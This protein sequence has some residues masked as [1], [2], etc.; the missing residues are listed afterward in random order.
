M[1]LRTKTLLA[2]GIT[3]AGLL[4]LLYFA[5]DEILL[6]G[7][8]RLEAQDMIQNV[9]R[10]EDA[11]AA[12]LEA[13]DS[14]ATDYAAWDDTYSFAAGDNP[15][16]AEANLNSQTFA[17]L[18]LNIWLIF[19]DPGELL[20]GR[21]FDLE[22]GAFEPVPDAMQPYLSPAGPLLVSNSPAP[23]YTGLLLVGK[24]V[25]LFAARPILTSDF[26]GPSLGTLIIGRYL[27]ADKLST[28]AEMTHLGLTLSPA[29][30][31]AA[32]PDFRAAEGALSDTQA[33]VVQPITSDTVAGYVF[34]RDVSS[35]PIAVLRA[36]TPRG[37]VRE[38]RETV[39]FFLLA[40]VAAGLIFGGLVWGL[41]ER[42]VLA[43]LGQLSRSVTAI[44]SS[45][46]TEAR[47][48]EGGR[49]E[50]ARVA[51][52]INDML[53][54]LSR[55]H[56]ATRASEEKF[57]KLAETSAAA[58]FITQGPHLRYANAR[59]EALTASP[60]SELVSW[61]LHP[62][63]PPAVDTAT[64]AANAGETKRAGQQEV[65]VV[66]PQGGA[67]WLEV[68]AGP[69]E[70]EGAPATIATA[71]DITDRK[72]AQ[73]ELLELNDQ[74]SRL[75]GQLERRNGES[76][77]LSQL[78]DLLQACP[79]VEE[80]YGVIGQFLPRLLPEL[81]CALYLYRASR[82]RLEA[83]AT[84]G[85][86]TS[87]PRDQALGPDTCWGLRLGRT[88][89]TGDGAPDCGHV[90]EPPA[91]GYLCVPITARGDTLGMLHIRYADAAGNG[92]D[93]WLERRRLAET[94][95]ERLGLALANVN[96]REALRHQA[97]R[98]PLT[99]LFNRRYMQETLERELSRAIR[100]GSSGAVLFLDLDHFK[101][102][103]DTHGHSAGDALLREIGSLF[104]TRL[105]AEDIAC[106]YG[107]EEFLLIMP[108]T[109]VSVAVQRAETLRAEV[110][111]LH[112]KHFDQLLNAVTLSV[113]VAV[114]PHHEDSGELIVRAADEAL[115]QAKQAGRNRVCVADG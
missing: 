35:R 12:E 111:G 104:R 2:V 81:G 26:A 46:N 99:G 32:A 52:A 33:I 95:G 13:L 62:P 9:R 36:E 4:A 87:N 59:A 89:S 41:L 14:T 24:Q 90:A 78:S 28:L 92:P 72:Q 1:S 61:P 17:N 57:R 75:V 42:L 27:D 83:V 71:Y 43:R 85:T 96:L 48:P 40:L 51:A 103:N 98:D 91:G 60:E 73:M 102:F 45:G 106:R 101:Q 30:D 16:Y 63:A 93:P 68:T 11:V 50:L 58:I 22:R 38:G 94:V 49:D 56:A 88:R 109:P 55:A 31:P 39:T 114:F 77:Q 5:A 82:D 20:Y 64:R 54:R 110:A 65:Q 8:T 18:G 15:T 105:R 108:E 86:L 76:S 115:Y 23:N 44:G 21:A 3:L 7:F 112:I 70:F 97:M 34:L 53:E 80:S 37:I 84:A 29:G 25:L 79:T 74:L 107:G 10:A 67:R 100:S 19:N 6:A 113:G 69:I 66:S 47:V